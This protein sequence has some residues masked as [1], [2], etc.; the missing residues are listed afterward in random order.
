M[1]VSNTDTCTSRSNVKLVATHARATL[2]SSVIP[3][4]Y[5]VLSESMMVKPTPPKLS[6]PLRVSGANSSRPKACCV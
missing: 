4:T 5:K 3:I 6:T 2:N 1:V